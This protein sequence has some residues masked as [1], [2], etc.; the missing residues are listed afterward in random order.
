MRIFVGNFTY[1]SDFMIVEDISSVIDPRMSL[2]ILG[3]PFVELYNM[4]YDSSLGIV[5]FTKGVIEITYTMPHKIEQYDSLSNE[6]KKNMKSVYFRNEEDKKKG[7]EYV[8]SKILGFYKECLELGPEHQT[9]LD[10]SSSS[11]RDENQGGVT[12]EFALVIDMRFGTISFCSYTSTDLKFRNRVFSHKVGLVV[13]NLDV[14]GLIEDEVMFGNLCDEDS[15][16]LCLILALEVIFMGRFLTCHVD[17]SLFGLVENLKAW[18]VFPYGEYVWIQLYDSIK[19]K[20]SYRTGKENS[21]G[22]EV[23]AGRRED[24]AVGRRE[25]VADCGDLWVGYMW[26]GRCENANWAMVSCF[27]V[28]L[29]MQNI[30]PLFYE[31]GDKYGIPWSDVDQVFI[32]INETNQHWYLAQLDILSGLITFYDS[33]DTIN[34]KPENYVIFE[35]N[36]DGVFNLHPLSTPRSILKEGLTIVGDDF[37]MN[38]MY[39]IGLHDN[40]LYEGLNLDGPIDVKGPSMYTDETVVC[41]GYSLSDI[42]KECFAN[43]VPLDSVGA[44]LQV[45]LKKKKGRSMVKVTRKRKHQYYKKINGFK[46]VHGKRVSVKACQGRLGGSVALNDHEV[47]NDQQLKS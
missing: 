45:V 13:T 32:P 31:N 7:V 16:R 41:D 23:E 30:M 2:V 11:R 12:P 6:E 38:K 33:E 1:A 8:M 21:I 15:V 14:L 24:V 18:N 42:Q 35:V 25:D 26:H 46:K 3:K 20:D 40:W 9:E 10:E 29:L 5:K 28:Q 34:E 44:N 36:Y 4:T 17:D 27:F 39:D 19:I 22:E 47:D 37:D 43:S